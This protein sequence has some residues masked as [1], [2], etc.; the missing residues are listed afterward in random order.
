LKIEANLGSNKCS[1][2]T[3]IVVAFHCEL[4]QADH[5]KRS[6]NFGAVAGELASKGNKFIFDYWKTKKIHI[7]K[8]SNGWFYRLKKK[9]SSTFRILDCGLD[10]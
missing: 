2:F 8:K 7:N 4:K 6:S 10:Y 3:P 9:L 1:K 5:K